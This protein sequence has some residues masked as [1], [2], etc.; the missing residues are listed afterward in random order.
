MST[1]ATEAS[2]PT[3]APAEAEHRV[4]PLEL[5]FDL[6]FVFALTQVTG[7][8]AADPTGPGLARGLL[9]LAAL[10]WA[11]AAYAWLTN[12]LN[13]DEGGVRLAMFAA[14]GAMLVASLSVP[15]AFDDS[16]LVFGIAYFVVRAMHIVLY[17]LP[18]R[19][20]RDLW[21]AVR[22]L[23]A[24][25]FLG[26]ALILAAAF[27]DGPVQGALWALA[28]AIDYGGPVLAG[29]AGW[30]VDPGHFAERHGLIVIIALG[31]SIVAVGVGAGGRAVDG[32]VIGAALLGIAVAAALWWAYFDVVAIV[33]E[34]RL[35]E[36]Q[37]VARAAMARD[38]YS[39]L[40][41]AMIAGIILFALGVKKTL[42]DF[43]SALKLVPAIGLCAGVS[44]YLLGHI[45]FRLRNV[46]SLNRQRLVAA[47]VCAA[48]V[49]VAMRVPALAGLGAI[50]AVCTL[51][52]AYVAIRFREARARVRHAGDPAGG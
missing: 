48:L 39:Y 40:H 44:L 32:G 8:L 15:E 26:P 47:A 46:R 16:A 19:G 6:V 27:F 31:E 5:F 20:D 50:S 18:A 9:V 2:A 43:D 29:M 52:I 38:S 34:R 11:W 35:Q 25:S 51:L 12:T 17:A 49:P 41:L 4:T 7:M 21:A 13:P 28:L 45:A 33:A 37:G 24:P 22:R 42:E 3:E 36:A 23:A 1:A 10:W 30:R 14:M